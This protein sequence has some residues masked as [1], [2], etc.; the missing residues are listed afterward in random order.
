MTGGT[1]A[2]GLVWG[3]EGAC[4]PW[5]IAALSRSLLRA[6]QPP[7][8][9]SESERGECRENS[10]VPLLEPAL[11]GEEN[12]GGSQP[13]LSAG[14]TTGVTWVTWCTRLNL[15]PNLQFTHMQKGNDD[16]AHHTGPRR[17]PNEMM[18]VKRSAGR[19]HGQHPVKGLCACCSLCLKHAP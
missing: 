4:R 7:P 19:A 3:R 18:E 1:K 11:R 2:P 9:A 12:P 5:H 6:I 8:G 16:T 10:E 15:P 13:A 17:G 14:S